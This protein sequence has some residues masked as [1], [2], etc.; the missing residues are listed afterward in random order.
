MDQDSEPLHILIKTGRTGSV[1]KI[2]VENSGADFRP[3]ETDEPHIA[4]NN[5]R[6]R[7]EMMCGGDMTIKPRKEGGTVV[8]VV[9]PNHIEQ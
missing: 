7:L 9:I 1:N 4:L 6:Q 5:I 3:A 8:T 2:I